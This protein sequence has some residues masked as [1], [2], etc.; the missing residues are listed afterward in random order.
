MP[1]RVLAAAIGC[2]VLLSAPSPLRAQARDAKPAAGPTAAARL[3]AGWTALA[4]GR[5]TEAIRAADEVLEGAPWNH[6]AMGLKLEALSARPGVAG[7][8]AYER[9]LDAHGTEDLGLLA[10][11]VIGM[12]RELSAGADRAVGMDALTLLARFDPQAKRELAKEAASGSLAAN[13]ALAAD[14][15]TAALKRLEQQTERSVRDPEGVVGALEGAGTAG[16]P[17][18]VKLL[19]ST[20]DPVRGLAAAALGRLKAAG[21]ADA[22]RTAA[23]DS[24]PFVRNSAVVALARLGDEAALAQAS[25]MLAAPVPDVQLLAAEAWDGRPG[26]WVE[27]VRALLTSTE[28]TVKVR[29]A[30]LLAGVDP[31]AARVALTETL[32]DANPAMR[33]FAAQTASESGTLVSV[34]VAHLRRLLREPDAVVRLHAAAAILQQIRG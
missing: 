30:R 14:G 29:A 15:D 16:V 31:E 13:A 21:A 9:W 33:A 34:E 17:S 18:L 22:L 27:T 1:P 11:V 25:A 24:D 2:V 23:R 20:A 7:L 28:G 8:D 32:A 5:V 6:M 19:S 26:P 4:R 3:A 12:L 10:P